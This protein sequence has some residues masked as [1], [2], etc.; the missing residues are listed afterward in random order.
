MIYV[1]VP[2]WEWWSGYGEHVYQPQQIQQQQHTMMTDMITSRPNMP[3]LRPS[4]SR[5]LQ[6]G[7]GAE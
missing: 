5:N 1:W 3:I 6:E 4:V 7:K 2:F